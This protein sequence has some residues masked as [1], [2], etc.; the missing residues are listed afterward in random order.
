MAAAL[1]TCT[2]LSA[3]AASTA[4]LSGS[5]S[6]WVTPAARIGA[7]ADG[8][9]V[10]ITVHMKLKDQD[11]LKQMV[12]DVSKPGSKLYGKYLS[13]AAFH[14]RFA[15]DA[16]DLSAVKA[17]LAGAGMT[18]VVVDSTGAFV[19][20]TATVA[21]LR[22]TFGVSQDLYKVGSRTLRANREAPAVPAAL[23][24]KIVYIE[25][26]DDSTLKHPLHRTLNDAKPLA[27]AS[28]SAAAAP[29]VTPPPVAANAPS[30]YCSTYFGDTR[31]TLS[32]KPNPYGATL[33]WLGCGYT[34]QQIQA[35]YGLDKVSQTG[36]GITVA[37]TDAYASPTLFDDS[38]RY[39]AN[40]GLPKLTS[41]N[42]S[43]IFP[44]GVLNVDPSE[45]C[46]PYG[47]WGE[48][49]LDMAAVHGTAPGANIL[50]VGSKD[51]GGTLT[52]ALFATIMNHR[53]DVIT[54]SWSFNAQS[55]V[56]AKAIY[57]QAFMAA[58]TMG[59]TVLFSSGDDGDLSQVNGVASGSGPG[60]SNYAT[61][62]GGTTLFLRS[63]DGTKSEY[64][65]GTY[66][67]YLSNALVNSVSSISTT[68]PVTTVV[69]G[70]T[71]DAYAF[72][73]GAGGG[74]SVNNL[75]PDYQVGVVPASISHIIYAADGSSA[76]LK[77]AR[78]MV[79]DVSMDADPY[80]GYLYGETMTS[81]GD[82]ILD[83]G[84]TPI[85]ATTEYC[86][87]DIGGTSLA[88]PLLAGVV[89]LLNE[90]RS[91]AGGA[92][93]GFINPLLYSVTPSQSPHG[94]P[95]VDILPP[96]APVALLRGYQSDATRVRVVTVNSVPKLAVTSPYPLTICASKVCEGLNDVFNHTT[97]GYDDVTG[98]GIPYAPL[99]VRK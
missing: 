9:T 67:D 73:S 13:A 47:W 77:E 46:G 80:S 49:S 86:E 56:G 45:P 78:R 89:A 6:P 3:Q 43:A 83:A 30:P 20:A 69:N 17:M 1:L 21:Q 99:L 38:N 72:Y 94:A 26:L 44:P 84:C 31:A 53:A 39:A 16:S 92:P 71:Y 14:A 59:I 35:A 33:P 19:S 50:Y 61:N 52:Q 7:A 97:P 42:F 95:L 90:A 75:Q 98:L 15:P 24:G 65:W 23:A 25:G 34:P 41:A 8:L 57:D 64:G 55:S 54:N 66:R 4:T 51:C 29:A 37:I 76:P 82:P 62:V 22:A 11:A 88:S 91:N 81:A 48:Q 63:A 28:Y 79:P 5:V 96:A 10:D 68:G 32:T 58:A 36:A 27:P 87:E 2:A 40:H 12:S 74:I 85:D 70:V 18:N 93:A 60:D